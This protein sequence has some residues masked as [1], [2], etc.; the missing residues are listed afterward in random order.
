ML[1]IIRFVDTCTVQCET[2]NVPALGT[3]AVL[4]V[5]DSEDTEKLD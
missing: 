4:L 1:V 2:N 3:T 5:S